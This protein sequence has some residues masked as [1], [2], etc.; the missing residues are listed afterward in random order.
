V[1]KFLLVTLISASAIV[2]GSSWAEDAG[3]VNTQTITPTVL[4]APVGHFQPTKK[5][6]SPD[7]IGNEIEQRKL[8]AFDAQQRQMDEMLDKKLNICRC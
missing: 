7:S 8:S 6:F 5:S 3:I 4:P 2:S 1:R